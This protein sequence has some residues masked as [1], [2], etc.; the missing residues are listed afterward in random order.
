MNRSELLTKLKLLS[1]A[2]SSKD[3]IPVLS[4]FCFLDG[5]VYAYDDLVAI[6]TPIED[7]PIRGAV[8]GSALL[9]F[10]GASKASELEITMDKESVLIKAGRSKFSQPVIPASQFQFQIPSR[11]ASTT[12]EPDGKLMGWLAKAVPV[13]GLDPVHPWRMGL[14]I[15]DDGEQT[16][17]YCSD[18][19]TATRVKLSTRIEGVKMLIPPK[20]CQLLID[21]HKNAPVSKISVGSSWLSATFAGG[22][23]LYSRV[24]AKPKLTDYEKIF[25]SVADKAGSTDIP[26]SLSAAL[27]RAHTIVKYAKKKFSSLSVKDGVMLLSTKSEHGSIKDRI[28][29]K[30]HPDIQ[31]NVSPDLVQ[32]GLS[33][34]DKLR[35]VDQCL[36]LTGKR[37][38]HIVGVVE[39]SEE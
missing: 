33:F 8:H 18:N 5:Q 35:I 23:K 14:T 1:P 16:L 22:T 10:L 21:L 32:R 31:V 12:I 29:L 36:V 11:E 27:L 34:A 39:T 7:C 3:L 28:A 17:L 38:T 2:L 30:T 25:E 4:H 13:M 37:C 15:Y 26:S 9:D 19:R 20:F 24:G 6:V